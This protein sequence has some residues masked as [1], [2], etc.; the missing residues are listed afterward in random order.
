MELPSDLED[1]LPRFRAGEVYMPSDDP[2]SVGW[3]R[4]IAPIVSTAVADLKNQR[5]RLDRFSLPLLRGYDTSGGGDD[6]PER[7]YASPVGGDASPE[8]RTSPART[9][10]L[11]LNQLRSDFRLV[12]YPHIDL[13]RIDELMHNDPDWAK[14]LEENGILDE[15]GIRDS[16]VAILAVGRYLASDPTEQLRLENLL[17]YWTPAVEDPGTMEWFESTLGPVVGPIVHLALSQTSQIP[18]PDQLPGWASEVGDDWCREFLNA[19]AQELQPAHQQVPQPQQIYVRP[20]GLTATASTS[21]GESSSSRGESEN[22]RGRMPDWL[23]WLVKVLR[24]GPANE[25]NERGMN[26]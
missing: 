14:A 10:Q 19:G 20:G 23:A 13:P 4:V 26:A 17:E 6:T 2:D 1:E 15:N 22:V 24:S 11:F 18:T 5:E 21:G 8:V 3:L 7:G 9:A 16:S 25:H 12:A